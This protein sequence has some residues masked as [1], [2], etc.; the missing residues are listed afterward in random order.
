M[1]GIGLDIFM[2]KSSAEEAE[3]CSNQ[4][5]SLGPGCLGMEQEAK[6]E[7]CI[8]EG[9]TCQVEASCCVRDVT[10]RSFTVNPPLA[11][12]SSFCLYIA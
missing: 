9:V 6:E 3:Y 4:L 8:I 12:P 7:G 1:V 10:V 11:I 5:A 2:P